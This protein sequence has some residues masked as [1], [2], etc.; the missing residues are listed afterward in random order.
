MFRNSSHLQP[1]DVLKF[2]IVSSSSFFLSPEAKKG[3]CLVLPRQMTSP[4]RRLD[5]LW[6]P[7]ILATKPSTSTEKELCLDEQSRSSTDKLKAGRT[8]LDDEWRRKTCRV[9]TNP[10]CSNT[11]TAA[12]A[13]Y[14]VRGVP[15]SLTKP[16]CILSILLSRF[17]KWK[18]LLKM[19]KIVL[20]KLGRASF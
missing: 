7:K 5:W 8:A 4:R 9:I 20:E 1:S 2:P 14:F 15:L 11:T 12:R 13:Y 18:C 16:S 10:S 3:A 6:G 17:L 19:S